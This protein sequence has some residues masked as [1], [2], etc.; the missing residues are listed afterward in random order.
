MKSIIL[1]NYLIELKYLYFRCIPAGSN[2]SVK[3]A[4]VVKNPVSLLMEIAQKNLCAATFVTP[5]M[6]GPSHDPRY[7]QLPLQSDLCSM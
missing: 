1:F 7:D 4:E 3:M 6:T 2:C 5:Y